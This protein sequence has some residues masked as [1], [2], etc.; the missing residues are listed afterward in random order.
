MLYDNVDK[1]YSDLVNYVLENGVREDNR[2]GVATL[3]CFSYHYNLDIS[4]GAFPLLTTKDMSGKVWHSLIH[5]LVWYLSGEEHIQN[6]RKQS[7][8]WDSWADSEGRLET[9]YGRFWRRYPSVPSWSRLGGEVWAPDGVDQIEEIVKALEIT[10]ADPQKRSRR[11]ILLAWHPANATL[12]KLPPCHLMSIFSVQGG[13]L[14]CHLTQRSGD[15][16]LGIPF[17]IACYSTL[18]HILSKATG[19]P[20]GTFG[21]TIIDAHIYCGAGE[22]DP[23]SHVKA[24]R[25]QVARSPYESPRLTIRDRHEGE[26]AL[27]YINSL[28]FEDFTLEGYQA[29]PHVKMKVAV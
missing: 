9:A 4:A 16:G 22:D 26:T 3:G 23:Y 15:I 28:R 13:K 21:H 5:E 12:S 6:F 8:I 29:H 18:M 7:K 10:A 24:L 11:M 19:I 27:D 17:N 20:V 25:G 2:T 1:A 14:H